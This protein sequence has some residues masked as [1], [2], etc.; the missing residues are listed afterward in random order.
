MLNYIALIIVYFPYVMYALGALVLL[1]LIFLA[2]DRVRS[3]K[4]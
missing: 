1:G 4:D 3:K 2:I